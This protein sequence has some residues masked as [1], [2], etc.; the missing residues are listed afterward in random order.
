MRCFWIRG[1]DLL[2]SAC[3][4]SPY[5]S[6]S[7]GDSTL[8]LRFWARKYFLKYLFL[9]YFIAEQGVFTV[10]LTSLEIQALSDV[11]LSLIRIND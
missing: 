6:L 10:L 3:L 7:Y 11:K 1:F 9:L 5:D 4:G 8:L 2:A